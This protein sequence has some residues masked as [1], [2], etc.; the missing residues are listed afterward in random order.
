MV[1][2]RFW[3]KIGKLEIEKALS[4]IPLGTTVILWRNWTERLCKRLVGEGGVNKVHYGQCESGE[5]KG[6]WKLKYG[7][8]NL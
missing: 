7:G 1:K 5:F 6:C 4:S 8:K 3:S 2:G